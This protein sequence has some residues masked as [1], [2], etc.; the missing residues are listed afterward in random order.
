M[1]LPIYYNH[2]FGI[3]LYKWSRRGKDMLPVKLSLR[4]RP[5]VT[6]ITDKYVIKLVIENDLTPMKLQKFLLQLLLGSSS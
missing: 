3:T 6:V 1:D 4:L 5:T 2:N